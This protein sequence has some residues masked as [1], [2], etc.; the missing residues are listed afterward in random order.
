M[1]QGPIFLNGGIFMGAHLENELHNPPN[2][3]LLENARLNELVLKLLSLLF[4]CKTKIFFSQISAPLNL[5]CINYS[6]LVFFRNKLHPLSGG[7]MIR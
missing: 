3:L 2:I 1:N 6:R 7:Q 4:L 5:I